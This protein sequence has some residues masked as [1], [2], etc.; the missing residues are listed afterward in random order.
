MN[1]QHI[2]HMCLGLGHWLDY[3]HKA[4]SQEFDIQD[5]TNRKLYLT[6]NNENSAIA[7]RHPHYGYFLE[8]GNQPEILIKYS[9]SPARIVCEKILE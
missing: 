8:G 5:S 7:D 2:V 6:S 9:I 4:T 3:R 1:L